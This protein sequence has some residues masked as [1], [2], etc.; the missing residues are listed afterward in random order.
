[1]LERMRVPQ[2]V[3][4][5][6]GAFLRRRR[7]RC[8][9]AYAYVAAFR[10]ERRDGALL[11]RPERRRA[12]PRPRP[13]PRAFATRKSATA[14]AATAAAPTRSAEGTDRVRARRRRPTADHV[15][16]RDTLIDDDIGRPRFV[17][18]KS[19]NPSKVGFLLSRTRL[20]LRCCREPTI[21]ELLVVPV[22]PHLPRCIFTF[23]VGQMILVVF[24]S[25]EFTE[26]NSTSSSSH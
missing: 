16:A 7:R 1:M 22:F 24:E 23:H 2:H 20:L 15:A 6:A 14:I 4:Y 12:R 17:S 11:A 25:R 13:R 19:V 18:S 5:I 21:I 9:Y 10:D 26:N 8:P 3:L